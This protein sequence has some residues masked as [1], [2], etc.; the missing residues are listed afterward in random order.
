MA[1]VRGLNCARSKSRRVHSLCEAP[2]LIFV[3]RA[4]QR[5]HVARQDEHTPRRVRQEDPG[6]VSRI[7]R[8]MMVMSSVGSLETGMWAFLSFLRPRIRA[9][10]VLIVAASRLRSLSMTSR[11]SASWV[12]DGRCAGGDM[13]C[14]PCAAV[15]TIAWRVV[16]DGGIPSS[17]AKT[18]SWSDVGLR[19]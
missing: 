1:R 2:T 6:A 17:E 12:A 3:Q 13:N 11:A 4:L 16:P 8:N 7:R 9:S 10:A 14:G 18:R 15:R 19:L 5:K